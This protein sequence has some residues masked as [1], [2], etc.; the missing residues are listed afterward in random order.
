MPRQ[1]TTRSV[2][3]VIGPSIAYVPLSR[4]LFS[5]IDAEDALEI[6]QHTWFAHKHHTGTFYGVRNTKTSPR[7]TVNMHRFLCPTQDD[8]Q[9][10]HKNRNPLDN[11]KSNLR[12]ATNAQNQWNK[13]VHKTN[14]CGLK[15]VYFSEGR[16]IAQITFNRKHMK[17]GR[18]GSAQQA[19]E[20]YKQASARLYGEFARHS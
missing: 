3:S 18:F 9:V 7:I 4:G 10:D 12:P 13:I 1:Y 19:H 16:W 15:G 11:R 2:I 5:L 20:A 8:L 6:G 17:I 14:S